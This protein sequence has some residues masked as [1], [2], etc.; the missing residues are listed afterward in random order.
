MVSETTLLN[1]STTPFVHFLFLFKN[2]F[3]VFYISF[4]KSFP[5]P[6]NKLRSKDH[7]LSEFFL[8]KVI[9]VVTRALLYFLWFLYV[10]TNQ[11][12]AYYCFPKFN[13]I[14]F[15]SDNSGGDAWKRGESKDLFLG[16]ECGLENWDL[17]LALPAFAAWPWG[18]WYPHIEVYHH[19]MGY[20]LSFPGALMVEV[21][22][23][24]S[25]SPVEKLS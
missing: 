17:V 5:C 8:M 7:E 1:Y 23:V 12:V 4:G 20:H 18:F 14:I 19:E 15:W 6:N 2:I 16:W 22:A 24:I 10:N 13:K 21:T 9:C 3:W 25:G 11:H